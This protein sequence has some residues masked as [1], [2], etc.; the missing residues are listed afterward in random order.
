MS[1]CAP[2]LALPR[3]GV[4]LSRR[5]AHQAI[6][7]SKSQSFDGRTNMPCKR[8][9]KT[10]PS[11]RPPPDKQRSICVKISRRNASVGGFRD[12][13]KLAGSLTFGD[14]VCQAPKRQPCAGREHVGNVPVGKS[15]VH[16]CQGVTNSVRPH[17]HLHHPAKAAAQH[18]VD[19]LPTRTRAPRYFPSSTDRPLA[20][21]EL[22]THLSVV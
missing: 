3:S 7:L 6:A 1:G 14:R 13:D 15:G 2:R 4:F 20:N 17:I 18:I 10:S 8:A 21:K 9:V 16:G 12:V 11:T 22:K 19:V 5:S